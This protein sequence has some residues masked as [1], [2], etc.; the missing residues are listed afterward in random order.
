MLSSQEKV[1]S[2]KIEIW[3]CFCCKP[4]IGL[5]LWIF[6]MFIFNTSTTLFMGVTL[7]AQGIYTP[8]IVSYILCNFLLRLILN[9]VGF[10]AIP[11]IT[12]AIYIR[13][14]SGQLRS[15]GILSTLLCII[16]DSI[17]IF[18]ISLMHIQNLILLL[19]MYI[20]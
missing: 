14:L 15:F 4:M 7:I 6:W 8:N 12:N 16:F 3:Y 11:Q 2:F 9:V 5:I 1:K 20:Y 13:K 19:Y 10:I 18:N 17:F